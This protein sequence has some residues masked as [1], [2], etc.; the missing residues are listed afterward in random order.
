VR[1]PFPRQEKSVLNP[2][3]PET[4]TFC[5]NVLTTDTCNTAQTGYP[6]MHSNVAM[7][8]TTM[9]VPVDSKG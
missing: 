8:G 7:L 3:G 9:P 4:E 6:A 1:N 2:V 5:T